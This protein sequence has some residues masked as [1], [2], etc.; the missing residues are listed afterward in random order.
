MQPSI[1]NHSLG[2][3]IDLL[4]SVPFFMG[5]PIAKNFVAEFGG[6]FKGGRAWENGEGGPGP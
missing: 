1:P 4:L 5:P 2:I 6:S 3:D